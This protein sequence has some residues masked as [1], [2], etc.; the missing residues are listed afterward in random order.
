MNSLRFNA[1]SPVTTTLASGGLIITTGGILVTANVAPNNTVLKGST[2]SVLPLRTGNAPANDIIVIQNNPSGSL[3]LQDVQL[4]VNAG[5]TTGLTKSGAGTLRYTTTNTAINNQGTG[6]ITIN[7]GTLQLN[8]AAGAIGA[9]PITIG[10]PY[11]AAT[12]IAALQL[13]N[14]ANSNMIDTANSPVTVYRTGTLSLGG[15]NATI[16]N[17]SG[18][19]LFGDSTSHGQVTTSGGTLTARN[20]TFNGGGSIA[21]SAG[22]LVVDDGGSGGSVAYIAGNNAIGATISGK[23]GLG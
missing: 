2:T 13:L 10:Q 14:P 5:T 1:H 8:L 23:V 7:A 9:G 18:F 3:T 15:S 20:L 12:A 4:G 21:T 17:N 11:A 6:P 22:K 19:S 16:Q